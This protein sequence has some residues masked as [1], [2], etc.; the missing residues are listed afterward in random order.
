MDYAYDL[1]SRGQPQRRRVFTDIPE[2]IANRAL[3]AHSRAMAEI[4]RD[5]IM[6][7]L[8]PFPC[9]AGR[10]ILVVSGSGSLRACEHRG[11]IVDLRQ[12][13]FDFQQALATGAM[14]RE[15]A[16]IAKD[17]CDCIHGCFVGNSLQHSPTAVL[18]RVLPK[19]IHRRAHPKPPVS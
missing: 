15:C 11:E 13:G 8:W 4:K 1:Y 10:K 5:R 3:Y 19:L 18:T 12:V 6:G 2:L 16:Q 7:Q 17:R 14:A 9:T